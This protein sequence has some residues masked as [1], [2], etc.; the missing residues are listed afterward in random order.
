[1]DFS[2]TARIDGLFPPLNPPPPCIQFD[3]PEN[4]ENNPFLTKTQERAEFHE[5]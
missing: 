2:F 3:K 5:I 1:M 4:M